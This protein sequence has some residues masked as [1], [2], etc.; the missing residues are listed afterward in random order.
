MTLV[1]LPRAFFLP[2]V[3]ALPAD[4]LLAAAVAAAPVPV[5]RFVPFLSAAAVPFF[6]VPLSGTAALAASAIDQ[7]WERMK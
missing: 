1:L 5:L 7:A 6:S 2:S 4:V 3:A